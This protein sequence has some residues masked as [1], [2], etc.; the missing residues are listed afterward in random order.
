MAHLLGAE[1]VSV[2]FAGPPVLAGVSLGLSDAD[3]V[4]VVG[5]NGEGKST[6]LALLA[7]R[8]APDS[9][10]VTR[11]TGVTV[12]LLDQSD[13]LDEAQTAQAAA[14]G[15]QFCPPVMGAVAFLMAEYAGV[16]YGVVAVAAALPAAL[17]YFG[18]LAAVHFWAKREGLSGIARQNLPNARA[19]L[20]ER[21]H[22]I[23]PLVSLIGLM[24]LGFTALFACILSM[25]VCVAAAALRKTTRMGWR[26]VVAACQEG[27]RGAVGVGVC[28]VVIGV[29]VGVVS[30]TGLGLKF[31]YLMLRVVGPGQ[32]L[33]CGAMV[34]LMATILGM[35]VPGIAAY[36]II[37]AVAVP[38][39]LKVG[40][41]PVPAHL[42]CLM[43]ASLS[44]ITPP[45]AISAYVAAGMAGGRQAKTGWLA[46]RVGLA[47]FLL[48]FYFLLNPVLLIGLAPEGT[49][50]YAA[51]L[52]MAGAAA[53]ALLL[54]AG[55]EGWF[56]GHCRWWQRGLLAGASLLLMAPGLPTD[57]AGLLLAAAVAGSQILRHGKAPLQGAACPAKPGNNSKE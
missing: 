37:A 18:M 19:V 31:G 21:G 23:A 17:Y 4:G 10:R 56:F 47:G 14:T 8:L 36:V 45:V 41:A 53:G 35:G 34:A 20:K 26:T 52:A 57:L 27:A 43:Y 5:R 46:M 54:A 24:A 1:A 42:F 51:P 50:F 12:G 49:P 33:L 22:L 39:M 6:L 2:A 40:C 44:N 55:T 16:S 32:L 38:V 9:G 13:T 25:A 28:C 15:G 3:R 30:L 48:P 7:G 11:R 29:V